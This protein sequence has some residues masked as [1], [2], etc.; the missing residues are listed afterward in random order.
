MLWAKKGKGKIWENEKQKLL[1][2][3]TDRNLRFDGYILAQNKE[4]GRKLT[5]LVRMCKFM[6]NERRMLMKAFI[7][8]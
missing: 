2:F 4:A 3:V 1:G 6:T 8:S 7:E 5:V